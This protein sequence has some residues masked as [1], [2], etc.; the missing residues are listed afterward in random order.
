MPPKTLNFD[1]LNKKNSFQSHFMEKSI[2][3][4][5][6]GQ[7]GKMLVESAQPWNVRFNILE[8]STDCPAGKYADIFIKGS[9]KDGNSIRKLAEVSDVLTYEIEHIDVQTLIELEASG[10][11]VIP[12]PKILEVIQ[13][14]GLQKEFYRKHHLPTAPFQLVKDSAE[15]KEALDQIPGNTI[16]LKTRTEGYDG[17]GVMI[18]R[19]DEAALTQVPKEGLLVEFFVESAI[20]ISVIVA[21]GIDGE[22]KSYPPCEMHFD[23][24][25]NLVD[26]LFAPSNL[27]DE[28]QN[29]AR[30]IATAAIEAFGGA[31]LFAVEMILTKDGNIWINEIA[32][33]PHNSG[34]HTIEACFTSQ[35]EQL[36]RI[37]QGL[38]LGSTKLITAGA[39]KNILGTSRFSGEYT[40]ESLDSV[41]GE[42]G[43]YLHM[44]N[45]K[46]TKPKRKMGHITALGTTAEIAIS[47]IK[48]INTDQLFKQKKP[49][50]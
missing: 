18:L 39:M 28:V 23:P 5:G 41:F 11:E 17:K 48:K 19:K 34:H 4:I 50:E 40:V 46:E 6:G 25:A 42:E 38:P 7:L 49:Q 36:I 1:T 26:F 33:R 3:I 13:D 10:K 32:P 21:R 45:K 35:Y 44:Y 16:V 12:S 2:G 15:L 43:I 27:A 20:E 29:E 30:T 9:L 24:E 31:G 37:L 8:G 47:K 14:K 22:I